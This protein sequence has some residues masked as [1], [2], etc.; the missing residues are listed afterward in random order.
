MSQNALVYLLYVQVWDVLRGERVG[1]LNGHENRVSCLGV[2]N[3]G[4]SLCTG[5]WDSLVRYLTPFSINDA[6]S[7]FPLIAQGLGLVIFLPAT[8][9]APSRASSSSS[10]SSPLIF[11]ATFPEAEVDT[12]VPYL[13]A[14]KRK[15]K[16]S[17]FPLLYFLSLFPLAVCWHETDLYQP[18]CTKNKIPLK[19]KE[20]HEVCTAV[21]RLRRCL[22]SSAFEF[23]DPSMCPLSSSD[24]F[25]GF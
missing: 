12:H 11:L 21:C 20:I 24:I 7:C 16:S 13:G 5:S 14:K 4:I 2:S 10:S 18:N 3:D 17:S 15:F 6:D 23:P 19:M 22:S 8:S 25:D 9:T 1:S